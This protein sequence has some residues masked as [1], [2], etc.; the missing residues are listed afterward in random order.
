MQM[1]SLRWLIDLAKRAGVERLVIDGSFVTDVLEPNDIDCALIVDPYYPH[2]YA[3]IQDQEIEA[4]LPF[5]DINLVERPDFTMP[6]DDF[7]ATDRF[8]TP[9][10]LIKVIS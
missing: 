10:G 9:N 4:G 6:V 7:F 5:L 3:A 1:Q 2:D 8:S